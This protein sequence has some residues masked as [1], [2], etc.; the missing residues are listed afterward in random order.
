[1][2]ARIISLGLVL[3]ALAGCVSG[4]IAGS[5]GDPEVAANKWAAK[6]AKR[7]RVVVDQS[8][9]NMLQQARCAESGFL[10]LRFVETGVDISLFFN[11]RPGEVVSTAQLPAKFSHAVFDELPHKLEFADWR[12]RILTPSSAVTKD[13]SFAQEKGVQQVKIDTP[14]YMLYGNKTTDSC[15]T[16]ADKATP[17]ECNKYL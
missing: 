16:P 15:I 3:S 2:I 5:S 14:L 11:C 9:A 17:K 8:D 13:I 1:M 6:H 4:P 12:F 7:L 10:P